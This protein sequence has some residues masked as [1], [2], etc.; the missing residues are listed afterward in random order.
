MSFKKIL[1]TLTLILWRSPVLLEIPH[2]ASMKDVGREIAIFKSD[3]GII[4][5]EHRPPVTDN[6]FKTLLS[7]TFEGKRKLIT[8]VLSYSSLYES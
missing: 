4:W 8:R 7:Q 6:D 2:F 3:D 5:Q 1:L